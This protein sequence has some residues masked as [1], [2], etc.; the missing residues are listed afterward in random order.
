VWSTRVSAPEPRDPPRHQG[1]QCAAH[2]R[3]NGQARS[4]SALYRIVGFTFEQWRA[5]LNYDFTKSKSISLREIWFAFIQF[6]W[7]LT[8]NLSRFDFEN[9]QIANCLVWNTVGLRFVYLLLIQYG[10]RCI[11]STATTS[12]SGLFSRTIWVNWHQ[13]GKPFWILLEQEMMRW[14]WHQLDHMQ[15][16]C[17]SLLTDNHASTAP[18]SFCRLDALHATHPTASK[19]W[20][21]R[22]IALYRK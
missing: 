5:D 1:W 6:D 13:K 18:L 20:R 17:T 9:C 14:Q 21:L 4:V 10:G 12:F 22:C 15:I 2:H 3:R 19:H 16:I 11:A 7:D 8:W